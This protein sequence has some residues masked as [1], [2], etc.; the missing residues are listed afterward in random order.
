MAL[1]RVVINL[2]GLNIKIEQDAPY[3]DIVTDMCNRA[4]V[5]FGTSIAQAKAAD[6]EIMAATWVDYGDDDEEDED[7]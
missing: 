5:L 4:A 3:P 6:L 2:G 1:A 7:A